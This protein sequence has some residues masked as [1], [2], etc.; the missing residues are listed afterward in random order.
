MIYVLSRWIILML[1]YIFVILYVFK[2]DYFLIDFI[3]YGIA[4]VLIVKRHG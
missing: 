1:K 3:G 4:I 2:G